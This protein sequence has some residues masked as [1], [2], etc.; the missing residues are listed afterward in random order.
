MAKCSNRWVLFV[1]PVLLTVLG[2]CV[3]PLTPEDGEA[4]PALGRNSTEEVMDVFAKRLQSLGPVQARGRCEL[5][6]R[7]DDGKERKEKPDVTLVFASP[8]KLF[9]RGNVLGQEMIRVGSNDKEFW[10]RFKPKELSSYFSG[11]WKDLEAC[12]EQ[13]MVLNPGVLLEVFGVVDVDSKWQ[14]SKRKDFDVLSK[15]EDEK[16]RKKVYVNKSDCL[17]RRIEYFDHRGHP[18]VSVN[19]NEYKRVKGSVPMP[20]KVDIINYM[21]DE[22]RVN[23]SLKNFKVFDRA[24]KNLF[25]RPGTK[26]FEHIY[27]LNGDCEFVEK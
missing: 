22:M 25:K 12:P 15:I 27:E 3:K 18:A 19:L 20:T 7:D 14:F 26:G 16:V 2:G 8:K 23:F 13:Q 4:S 21:L 17:V 10:L 11:E 24:E 6:W 5:I 9:V 1:V